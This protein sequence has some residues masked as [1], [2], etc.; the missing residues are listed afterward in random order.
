MSKFGTLLGKIRDYK[1]KE[2]IKACVDMGKEL[3]VLLQ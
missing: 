2:E 1:D 3:N